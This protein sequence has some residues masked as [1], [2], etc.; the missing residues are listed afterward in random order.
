MGAIT[1]LGSKTNQGLVRLTALLPKRDWLIV[2]WVL[3]IKGLIF[4]FAVKSYQ[5]LADDRPQGAHAWLEIWNRW[6]S[7][8]YQKLA[9]FGY[10][11]TGPVKTWFYPLFPW[12][13][14]LVAFICRDYLASAF[15]V[16]GLASLAAALLLRRVVQLDYPGSVAQRSVWFFLIF[17]TA[18]FLHIGYTESLFLAFVLGCIF[19][20]R[21]ERWWLAGILGAL[22]SM[23]RAPGLMLVP[24][25]GVEAMHQYYET[26]RWRWHWFWIALVPAGFGIYLLLNWRVTGDPWTFLR[27]RNE[28]FVSSSSWPWNGIQ[29]AIGNLNRA[30]SDAEMVAGQELFFIVLGFLCAIASWIKLRPLYG[31]W[32]TAN[33]LL[34]TSVS[35]V[36]SVPRY[37][38]AMFPIF[39]LFAI[40]GK[41]R[42]WSALITV[43]SLFFLA[44]FASLFSWGHWAF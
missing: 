31:M 12:L 44:L 30:P 15:I 24:T 27:V 7:I 20:A 16:S 43:W 13:V 21:R 41:S 33:W 4:F 19:A 38:L 6:D 35:F 18:Y 17:P 40:L 25:L 26:K 22:S 11:A 5:I 10:D 8:H 14:R 2:G 32:I 28:I 37:S 1:N 23:T 9:E 42:F 29:N 36:Q 39:V 3:A 34:V